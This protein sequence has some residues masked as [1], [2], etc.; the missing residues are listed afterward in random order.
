VSTSALELK[1]GNIVLQ[2][3]LYFLYW[4]LDYLDVCSVTRNYN[5][6]G[7]WGS[8]KTGKVLEFQ[9]FKCE[10]GKALDKINTQNNT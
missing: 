6:K 10:P 7:F 3:T 5:E 9:D 1:P 8:W 4:P 2:E